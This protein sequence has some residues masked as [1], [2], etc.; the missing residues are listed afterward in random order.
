M[1]SP[2]WLAVALRPLTS[3]VVALGAV[4]FPALAQ[5]SVSPLVIE[6]TASQGQGQGVIILSNT[7]ETPTRLRVYAEPFTYGR[8]GLEVLTESDQDLTPYLLFSPRELVIEPGQ[9]RMVRLAA[10]LLPSLGEGE[11]RAIVFTESLETMPFGTDGNVTVGIIPRVGVT[12]YVRQ[13]NVAPALEV[14]SAT[15]QPEDGRIA[16][17]VANAGDATA[18]PAVNWALVHNG[19]TQASGREGETTVIAGGDRNL[20]ID[21]TANQEPP[22]APGTYTL[23]GT[24]T[25]TLDNR[26]ETLPFSVPVT[27]P[28]P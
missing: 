18:R 4:G 26:Q 27:L 23:S 6:S 8:D 16:L 12:M 21:H 13:G 3:A 19:T 15:V 24:L 11:F 17:L 5:L 2:R 9:T 7:G 28:A 10:R 20:M 1:F 14:L 25:W 22:L